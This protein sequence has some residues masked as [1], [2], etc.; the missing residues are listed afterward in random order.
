MEKI[1]VLN[2]ESW[3]IPH[4][5][6]CLSPRLNTLS[7]R[8]VGIVGQGH[9]P[10]LYLKD[11]LLSAVPDIKDVVI[12]GVRDTMN[13]GASAGFSGSQLHVIPGSSG[14]E[15]FFSEA[16]KEEL[17]R[18]RPDAVIQGIAH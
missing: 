11:A 15:G 9:S 1:S 6:R 17:Y 2:P 18:V 7:G 12:L 13:Q 3:V 8:T 14:G 5:V 10:M 16:E 4:E